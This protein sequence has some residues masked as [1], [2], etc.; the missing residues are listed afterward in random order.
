MEAVL[1]GAKWGDQR[2]GTPGG[3]VTWSIAGAGENLDVF[4]AS[5]FFQQGGDVFTEDEALG[6]DFALQTGEQSISGGQVFDFP[7]VRAIQR[8]FDDWALFGDIDLVRIQD[9]GGAAGAES[10]AD[11][12]VFFGEIPGNVI[13]LAFFPTG[14]DNPVAGDIL[15]DIDLASDPD[16][17][18]AT[19]RHEIGH[20]IGFDHVDGFSVLFPDSSGPNFLTDIDVR[21]V[22][23]LYG[24]RQ[25]GPVTYT[26]EDDQEEVRLLSPVTNLIVDGNDLDNR[27]FGSTGREVILGGNGN[28]VLI[29]GGGGDNLNGGAGNDFLVGSRLADRFIGGTGID[30]VSYAAAGAIRLDLEDSSASTGEAAG[31]I[32]TGVERIRGS[33][34]DDV[35]LGSTGEDSLFGGNGDDRIIGRNGDDRIDGGN[36]D[37]SLTGGGG[38]DQFIG[39]RGSDTHDGGAGSDTITYAASSSRVV[40]DLGNRVAGLNDAAGDSFD[41][42]ENVIGTSFSDELRG[43]AD[44]NMLRGREGS[45]RLFGFSGNDTLW[46]DEGRDVLV[47]GEGRD[48]LT[49]GAGVDVFFFSDSSDSSLAGGVDRITDF[50]AGVDRINLSRIDAD[51]TTEGDQAFD[52]VGISGPGSQAG[53]LRVFQSV[54]ANSTTLLGDID[55]DGTDD[56]RISFAGLITFSES[57]FIL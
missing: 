57:D 30:T 45:D 35:L 5:S 47:G 9:Q 13:G 38:N 8:A 2:V 12:R 31:D 48:V 43:N 32:F 37:D 3:V 22:Q 51:S 55:G 50:T 52:F 21:G 6:E 46:G 25:D 10:A 11:I 34:N 15:I 40:V 56:F 33:R 24:V 19:V 26:F 20:A 4:E 16:E 36:G 28:D 54:G 49:G 29:G 44:G 39:S 42:V 41:S 7:F 27:I 53:E 18:L 17:F 1:T 14:D 23:R